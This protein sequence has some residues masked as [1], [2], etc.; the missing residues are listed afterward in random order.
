M[1]NNNSNGR[2]GIFLAI[3]QRAIC[4]RIT[5]EFGQELAL[6]Y[7]FTFGFLLIIDT[8]DAHLGLLEWTNL[9]ISK[10]FFAF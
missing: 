1:E 10:I 5:I 3:S 4:A 2:A 6:V 7:Y 9:D 8:H